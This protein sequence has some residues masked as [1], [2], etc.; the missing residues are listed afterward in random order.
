VDPLGV[1][2]VGVFV[3]REID[4]TIELGQA[5]VDHHLGEVLGLGP[6]HAGLDQLAKALGVVG[7]EFCNGPGLG[8]FGKPAADGVARSTEVATERLE[9]VLLLC[10]GIDFVD[11]DAKRSQLFEQQI[12]LALAAVEQALDAA[13]KVLGARPAKR[14]PEIAIAGL[15]DLR[16]AQV[17]AWR[18]GLLLVPA[19]DRGGRGVLVHRFRD[20][21]HYAFLAFSIASATL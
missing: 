14:I 6:A 4:R 21:G 8:R 18:F 5:H 7:F 9:A 1:D 11:F 19:N 17:W 15:A 12:F 3:D 16:C 20:C 2:V 10:L 13:W